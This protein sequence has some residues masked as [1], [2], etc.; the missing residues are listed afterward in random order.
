[1]RRKV[2]AAAGSALLTGW[3]A[4]AVLTRAAQDPALVVDG[5]LEPALVADQFR[6]LRAAT[7]GWWR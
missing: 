5:L 7:L 3:Q 2:S 6:L 4:R 1:M